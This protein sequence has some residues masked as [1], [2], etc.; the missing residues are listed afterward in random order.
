M[1]SL[2]TGKDTFN[3]SW[4]SLSYGL[5]LLEKIYQ[6]SRTAV[7]NLYLLSSKDSF[8]IDLGWEEPEGG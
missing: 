1:I 6:L 8:W 5:S 7:Y 3:T 2:L 4:I